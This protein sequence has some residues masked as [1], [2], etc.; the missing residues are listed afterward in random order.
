VG[1][2]REE[3]GDDDEQGEREGD[4]R[5]DENSLKMAVFWVVAS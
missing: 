3:G 1:D 4:A 5:G 2:G